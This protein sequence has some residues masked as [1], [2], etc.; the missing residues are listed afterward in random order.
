MS[1]AWWI[2]LGLVFCFLVVPSMTFMG[3]KM[4]TIGK[5]RGREQ[6]NRFQE[7]ER[8]VKNNGKKV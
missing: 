1:L 6:F 4:W 3:G 2:F 8:K 5:L 7:E